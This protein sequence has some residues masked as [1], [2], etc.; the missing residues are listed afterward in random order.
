MDSIAE[1]AKF[2]CVKAS[3][4]RKFTNLLIKMDI[5]GVIS[6]I[7]LLLV[8]GLKYLKKEKKYVYVLP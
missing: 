1:C 4:V 8:Y 3:V 6:M 2:A 5:N 7:I